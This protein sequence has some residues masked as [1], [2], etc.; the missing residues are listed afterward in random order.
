MQLIKPHLERSPTYER[1]R[2]LALRRMSILQFQDRS[3]G[4]QI[5]FSVNNFLGVENSILIQ[6]YASLD[7][8]FVKLMFFLKKWNKD[9]FEDARKRLPSY[10]LS[11]MLIVFMQNLEKPILPR[12]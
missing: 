2:F 6:S 7:A 3:T 9:N 5:D 4:M 11:L 1:V 8:R 10:A 12:L